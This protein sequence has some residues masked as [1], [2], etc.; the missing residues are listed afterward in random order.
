MKT[1]LMQ[2]SPFIK[3]CS[4]LMLLWGLNAC[5]VQ[6]QVV[7]NLPKSYMAQDHDGLVYDA[8]FQYKDFQAS[9]LLVMKRL[10]PS[11]YHV[12]LLSKFGPAIMEF[13]LDKQGITWIKTF[14]RLDKKTLNKLIAKDFNLLFL[15]I[16]EQPKKAKHLKTADGVLHYKIKD[17]FKAK[18]KA[19]SATN[20][21]VYA[22]T[23]GFP[24]LFKSK[25]KFTYQENDIPQN[26][27]LTHNNINLRIDLN[28]LKVNHAER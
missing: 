19:D 12:V 20:R 2:V 28:L 10:Q 17:G 5:S 23:K 8:S 13:T 27:V 18:V 11:V 4:L 14:D 25:A 3:Y 6:K 21:I 22:A 24:N 26:I 7:S 1:F 16:L 9:G 15:S